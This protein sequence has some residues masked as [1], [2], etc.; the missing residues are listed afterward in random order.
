[1]SE[2]D[3][4][5][6]AAVMNW[7]ERVPG[8][9]GPVTRVLHLLSEKAGRPEN[10][11]LGPTKDLAGRR[12]YFE[13]RGIERAELRLAGARDDVCL[14]RL[15]GTDLGGIQAVLM[16]HPRYPKAMAWLG[17][18]HPRIR[19]I[20]RGHNAELLHQLHTVLAYLTC[21][22][23]GP[24][25]RAR[26]A[27][28]A[29]RNALRRVSLDIACARRADYV[30]AVS[31]WEAE[32]Y[33][34]RIA[35]RRAT[36]TV[37]YFLPEGY[38]EPLSETPKASRVVCVMSAAW[39]PLGHDAA[40]AL[41]RLANAMPDVGDWTFVVT[42]DLG[43][44]QPAYA[45]M[46]ASGRVTFTSR[47]ANP[48]AATRNA[49]VLAHL[50]NLGMGFKTKFLDFVHYGGWILMPRKLYWRQP[51]ELRPH[52]IVVDPLSP[53]AF[54]RALGKAGASWP[55]PSCVTERLR[56]RAFRAMDIAFGHA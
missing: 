18:T 48:F 51:A 11:Y 38:R 28:A 39:N 17:R 4:R 10:E 12:E 55:D 3:R 1:M 7:R 36:L 45:A 50:S 31:D 52:C 33:W 56:E 37:P 8:A 40:R 44:H 43:E 29:A 42:G 32:H 15:R 54:T 13:A 53:D 47:L 23:G 21:G 22:L 41:V 20:V 9:S 25:W 6:P 19:Q 14:D 24:G 26:R 5:R 49:R 16:E 46:Q 30:L 27:V 34:P 2:D 35:P